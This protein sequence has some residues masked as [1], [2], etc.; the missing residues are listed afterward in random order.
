M[1]GPAIGFATKAQVLAAIVPGC[2][3]GETT[4][5]FVTVNG[6]KLH[7]NRWSRFPPLKARKGNRAVGLSQVL[8]VGDVHVVS[9]QEPD[10]GCISLGQSDLLDYRVCLQI[11]ELP[12]RPK[13]QRCRIAGSA[14]VYSASGV[15]ENLLHPVL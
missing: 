4:A 10:R 2:N 9:S 14:Q 1:L 6:P 7:D 13:R 5:G 11:H 8:T 15:G 12:L 3:G